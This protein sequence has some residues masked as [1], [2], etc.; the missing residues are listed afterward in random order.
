[1]EL[2][3]GPTLADRI[4]RGP[5][6]VDEALPIAK[7]I[8]VA[9]EAAH[10]QAIVH[11]DLKPANVGEQR[12]AAQRHRLEELARREGRS[13]S[14]QVEHLIE[15]G[16]ENESPGSAGASARR[17]SGLLAR[18]PSPEYGLAAARATESR[19]VS[20]DQALDGFRRRSRL[21]LSFGV[22]KHS[23]VNL[24]RIGGVT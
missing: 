1:M 18:E 13:S 6:P 8:A 22:E 21:G 23:R 10:A 19:L 12:F 2:V 11:S 9:L 16:L 14:Q 17:L 24:H 7:Q 3:E 15:R 5:L 20:A 4:A